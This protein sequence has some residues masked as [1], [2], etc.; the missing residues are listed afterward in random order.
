LG[1][2][3]N[4]IKKFMQSRDEILKNIYNLYIKYGF[5]SITIDDFAFQ[6]GISKKTIYEYF[7]N[8]DELIRCVTE[9]FISNLRNAVNSSLI[10]QNDILDKIIGIYSNLIE[11]FSGINPVF[12]L[13]LKK[14][15]INH[16]NLIINYRDKEYNEIIK[17]L[18]IEGIENGIFR[19]DIPLESI[20][21]SQQNYFNMFLYEKHSTD[22]SLTIDTN[23]LFSLLINGV[24]GITTLEGH[25]LLNK[26]LNC[27][28]TEN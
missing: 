22:Q 6:L 27:S 10:S 20:I 14:H 12:M 19:D 18:M 3:K 8:K 23:T 2:I 15:S 5:K 16:Y 25:K 1:N 24:R 13:S 28:N 4:R 11:C 7:K 9:Q 17:K 26:K 21:F